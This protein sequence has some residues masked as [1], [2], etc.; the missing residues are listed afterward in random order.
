MRAA[1]K[2]NAQTLT[3][4]NTYLRGGLDGPGGG[5]H[6]RVGGALDVQVDLEAQEVVMRGACVGEQGGYG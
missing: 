4:A 1:P 2:N 6:Q 3:T 5:A